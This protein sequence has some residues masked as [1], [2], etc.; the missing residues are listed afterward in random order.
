ML[1]WISIADSQIRFWANAISAERSLYVEISE[2][3]ASSLAIQVPNA[4]DV[5]AALFGDW[6]RN[7]GNFRF[8]QV[9]I[10]GIPLIVGRSG[11][12]KQI[13]FELYLCDES[14][15]SKL[16]NLVRETGQPWD[17]RPGTPNH[18]KRIEPG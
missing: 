3:D 4:E 2:P 18:S 1:F 12:S 13:G 6:L 15:G 8:N 10:E 14:K 16:W 5:V 7:L 11:Y 17:I 9:Q